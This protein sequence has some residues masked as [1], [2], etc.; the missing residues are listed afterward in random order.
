MAA[1]Y[2]REIGS[3]QPRGPYAIGGYCFGAIVA[4]EMARQLRARGEAVALLA[5]FLG[6]ARTAPAAERARL[7]VERLRPLGVR[8]RL[9]YVLEGA[10]RAAAAAT[11]SWLWRLAY[12][13][14]GRRARPSSRLLRNVPQMNLQAARR[15]APRRYE[16]A[17]TVF[18]SGNLDPERDLAGMTAHEV[19]VVRV[20][21]DRDSMLREPCVQI[22]AQRLD[23]CLERARQGK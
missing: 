17:M 2:L 14:W 1:D 13:L 23:A 20:P 6:R 16:G 3:V 19:E 18:A 8:G 9:A 11:T 10:Y 5:L 22:L 7:H 12:A 21:G 15:Y 4:F